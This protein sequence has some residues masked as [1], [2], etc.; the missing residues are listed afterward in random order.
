[1]LASCAARTGQELNK[2]A[3]VRDAGI[4]RSTADTYL[5]LLEDLS[6]VTRVPA[7][8]TKRLYRL[9]RS[10]KMHLVDPGMAAYLLRVDAAALARDASLVGQLFE[11]FVATELLAHIETAAG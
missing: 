7:W 5:R 4:S 11:T 8:H 10:P 3:T 1:M 6:I 2:E 9:T